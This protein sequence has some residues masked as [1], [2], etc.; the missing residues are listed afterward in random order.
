MFFFGPSK[1]NY[2]PYRSFISNNL[3]AIFS[4]SDKG[5]DYCVN[6][7]KIENHAVLKLSRLGVNKGLFLDADASVFLLVSCSTVI[8][9]KRVDLIISSLAKIKFKMK[10]VHFGDGGKNGSNNQLSIK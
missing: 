6:R 7:W 8:P 3:D 5:I 10:W 4:I 1:Y 2:L 9:L